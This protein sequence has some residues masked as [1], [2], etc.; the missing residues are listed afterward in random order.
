MD[1][2]MI[3]FIVGQCGV[4]GVA[5]LALWMLNAN[6]KKQIGDA[7]SRTDVER[8]DKLLLADQVRID[9]KALEDVLN[10]NT[11][12]MVLMTEVMRQVCNLLPV[13]TTRKS[14]G[15]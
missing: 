2:N 12:A 9:K 3:Q 7:N 5:A 11:E 14:A 10:R 4:G 6:A 8:T 15:G 13:K 1:Q